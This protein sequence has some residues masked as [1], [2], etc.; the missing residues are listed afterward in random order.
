[1]KAPGF[2]F[3]EAFLHYIWESKYFDLRNL[4]TE[5]Q[6]PVH[7]FH[8]GH[9]NPNQGPDFLKTHLRIGNLE[10]WGNV[11]IHVQSEEWYTHKHHQDPHYDNTILHV[12]FQSSGKPILRSDG[13]QIPEL[14]LK[15]RIFEEVWQRYED[16]CWKKANIPCTGL[17]KDLPEVVKNS[18]LDRLA[19]ERI[20]AKSTTIRKRLIETQHNWEQVL[21]ENFAGMMGGPINKPAFT[22]LAQHLPFRVLKRYSNSLIALESMCMGAAGW[23]Q[24]KAPKGSDN[25]THKEHYYYRLQNEW[26]FLQKKHQLH[27]SNSI[28]FHLHRM[29]P[30]AF[31][32]LRLAQLAQVIHSFHPFVDL[33]LP[34]QMQ[35]F[36]KRDIVASTYWDTHYFFFDSQDFKKKRLGKDQKH[37][38]TTNV[39]VPFAWIFLSFH[40]RPDYTSQLED[41]LS[42]IPPESNRITRKFSPTIS[43]PDH[44]FHAQGMIQLY[45]HYCSEKRCL[46]CAI[47]RQ[48]LKRSEE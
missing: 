9:L 7:I 18:W 14:V 37:I 4:K 27:V 36:M 2:P 41:I 45:K 28:P 15:D 13:T 32:T 3:P 10:W 1:M 21:W 42:K 23:L 8:S 16:L 17:T 40:G 25:P 44:A 30:A 11:E 43:S 24:K 26:H 20:L 48:V 29:R 19:V 5:D 34:E 31:P 38:L 22:H 6:T 12:V 47:G 46:E 39:L 33:C 35:L